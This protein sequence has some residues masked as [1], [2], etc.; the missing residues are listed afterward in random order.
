MTR[1]TGYRFLPWFLLMPQ[2]LIIGIFFYWPAIQALY[3]SFQ[4]QDIFGTTTYWVGLDNFKR[5]WH[6]PTYWD[7]IYTTL[8]FSLWVT[9]LALL[10]SLLTAFFM[11]RV[12]KGAVYY[13]TFLILPYAISPI[14]V[15]VLW[16]FMFSPSFG[17]IAYLLKHI[18]IDWN[19]Q[20]NDSQAMWLVI[21]ASVWKQISYNFL[22][23]YA[24]LQ[25]IPK[26]LIEAAAID[27]AGPWKRFFTIQLPLL[28]PTTFFLCV[29]NIV[30]AFFDTFAIID[31]L[32][33]G[34]PGKSTSTLVYRIYVEG[35][36][37]MDYGS[38][39]AQ[40][41]ILMAAVLLLTLIQFRYMDQKGGH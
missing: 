33:K 10:L 22:F 15:G 21:L 31:S 23:F 5:L 12:V 16:A 36:M 11:Y 8:Y 3:Q 38:S 24:G 14:I 39:A 40:S 35:F 2:L 1:Y 18:G 25:A 34:G 28:W 41:V 13:R 20:M 4:M 9:L 6:D 19:H 17:V 29:I 32:T 27:G 26:S 30:Y 7:S 37:S